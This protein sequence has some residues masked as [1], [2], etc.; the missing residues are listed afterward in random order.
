MKYHGPGRSVRLSCGFRSYAAKWRKVSGRFM[1]AANTGQAFARAVSAHRDG[2]L[3]EAEAIYQ[4]LLQNSPEHVGCLHGLAL[5]FSQTDRLDEALALFGRAAA[6]APNDAGVQGDMGRALYLKG[7]FDDARRCFERM[8]ELEPANA[9]AHANLGNALKMLG[10]LDRSLES[11]ARALELNAKL[12]EPHIVMGGINLVKGR[13]EDSRK[14]FAQA[15]AARPDHAAA[16]EGLGNALIAQGRATD[17]IATFQRLVALRPDS[18]GAHFGLANAYHQ[19]GRL[20]EGRR[21][22][23][24]AIVLAPHEPK[25]HYALAKSA[26]FTADDARLPGLR[27]LERRSAQMPPR[28]RATLHF[29]LAKAEEDLGR[30]P[31]AFAHLTTANEAMRSTLDYDSA[32]EAAEIR[33][34][35]DLVPARIFPGEKPHGT[36]SELPI[37]VVGMPRSGTSLVEQVLASHPQVFG[38]GEL[39][40]FEDEILAVIGT[41][42]AS[43]GEPSP[44]QLVDIGA[45]YVAQLRSL[46]PDASRI[47][48]K[49][50]GNFRYLGLIH[51][52]LPNARIIHVK[53]DALDTCF[54]CYATL[55]ESTLNFTY[56]LT[57]LGRIYNAYEDLMAHWRS[58][59][60]EDAMLE[61]SYE[62]LVTDFEAQVG[63]LLAFCD[64]PWDERCLRFYEAGNAV[65][66]ASQHQV[67]QRLFHSSIARSRNY[68]RW[69][70]PLSGLLGPGQSLQS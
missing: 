14:G 11:C 58:V 22:L 65:R 55:F 30:Y 45:R 59:L 67:R 1:H 49:M 20:A 17:A 37:F 43:W 29:A 51:L 27:S 25:L 33:S 70:E 21:A 38:G 64:L 2:K 3:A 57:D 35:R 50:P 10:Q 68:A 56:D 6:V 54:S 42:R 53:R 44:R 32:A 31:E 47:T 16:L 34:I 24:Q 26:R 39:P 13:F 41:R 15:L 69:L 4:A 63:R 62:E 28:D 23:E 12:V 19:L 36:G 9:A 40:L 46:A 5:I 61:L 8:I 48:D 52:A 18:A 66:T 7:R 60:P